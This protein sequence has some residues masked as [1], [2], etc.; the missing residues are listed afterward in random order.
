M[1]W[2]APRCPKSCQQQGKEAAAMG[3]ALGTLQPP[4]APHA[5]EL[6]WDEAGS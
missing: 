3:H 5:A 6:C 2:A 4:H 1:R